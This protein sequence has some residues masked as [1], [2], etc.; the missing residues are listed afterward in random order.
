MQVQAL[1]HVV[2]KVRDLHRS[3]DFYSRVLGMRIILRI[4]DPRMTF[5]TL[6]TPGSRHDFALMELGPAA[7]SRSMKPRARSRGV[8]G[9][10][11]GRGA[12]SRA[13]CAPCLGN[14]RPLRGGADLHE[15]RARPRSGRERD[16]AVRRHLDGEPAARI[17]VAAE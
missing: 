15:E 17:E 12:Q 9:R 14:A 16:R 8:Q 2:L 6:G 4:S 7:R 1:G 13:E 3:E 5:F 11:I 10:Q